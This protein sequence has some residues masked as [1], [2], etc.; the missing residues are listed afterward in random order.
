MAAR[1]RPALDRSLA[2]ADARL[3]QN[4]LAGSVARRSLA[5]LAV[6]VTRA[7]APALAHMAARR[8]RG[9]GPTSCPLAPA[10]RMESSDARQRPSSRLA[11]DRPSSGIHVRRRAHSWSGDRRQRHDFQLG[12]NDPVEAPSRSCRAGPVGGDSRHHAHAQQPELLVSELSG[13]AQ[14]AARRLRG[15]DC[16]SHGRDEPARRRRSGSRLGRAGDAEFLRRPARDADARAR[17]SAVRGGD[18]GVGRRGGD[19]RKPVA[20]PVRRGCLDCWPT[21]HAERSIVLRHRCRA[22]RVPRFHGRPRARHV[23]ADH[24]AESDHVRRPV[25]VARQL[26]PAGVRAAVGR[27]E[28][29]PCAGVSVGRRRPPGPTVPGHQQGPW[30]A[31]RPALS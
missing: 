13:S 15:S 31:R 27:F 8:P 2:A 29:G 23:R 19:Q 16:V 14:R 17:F 20:P 6:A 7:V 22:A 24:D 30:R 3:A 1:V 4:E 18:A 5:L 28:H 21:D 10:L 9:R 11:A 26:V 25:G 12:G